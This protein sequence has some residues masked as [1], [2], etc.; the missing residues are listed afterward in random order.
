MTRTGKIPKLANQAGAAY[1]EVHPDDA[2]SHQ[3][4]EGASVI[5]E[6]VRGS[7]RVVARFNHRLQKGTLFMPFHWGDPVAAANNVTNDAYDPISREP[8]FKACAVRLYGVMPPEPVEHS[9]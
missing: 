9:A 4:S 3:I 2:K 7:A 8:E 1:V 5:V 6:S